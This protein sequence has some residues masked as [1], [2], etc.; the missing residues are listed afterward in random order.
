MGLLFSNNYKYMV[1]NVFLID[2]VWF[3][4]E[5]YFKMIYWWFGEIDGIVNW[6]FILVI[7]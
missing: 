1:G 4:W 6:E 7:I 5:I 3:Y 2:Y